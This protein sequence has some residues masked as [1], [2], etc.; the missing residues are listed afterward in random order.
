[1]ALYPLQ[2]QYP[3]GQ[4]DGVDSELT[5]LLGGE[6]VGLTSYAMANPD[7]SAFDSKD[8]Y[9]GTAPTRR[10]IVTKT[11]FPNLR[12]LFLADEG[13]SGYGTLFGTLVGGTTG[14][15]V[16]G[17]T[18]LGPHTTAGSG[19]VTCW[20]KPGLYAVTLD[21]VDKTASTGL[22]PANNTLGPGT[23]LY[24]TTGG[25]L[26]P[27]IGSAFESVV[28]ARFIDFTTNGSLVN[29]PTSLVA[30][31]NSPSG[32]VQSGVPVAFTRAVIHFA[33]GLE[34]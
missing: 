6:V 7:K 20:D 31:V 12:P 21:A 19:K 16:T 15:I 10:P 23:A 9:S 2:A 24:A 33:G 34:G 26:T 11:L 5:A 1:M 8:G 13:I 4:F 28:V 14:Q 18:T 29:T 3:L 30:A 25:L 27:I 32:N 17:G 22:V